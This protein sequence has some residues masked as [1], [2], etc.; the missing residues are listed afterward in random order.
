NNQTATVTFQYGLTVAYGSTVN[1]TPPTV[2]GVT[3][4]GVLAA[5]TGLSLSTTY[6]FR[7]VAVNGTGT[8]NGNDMI[9]TTGC[10]TPAA[11]G[12]ITGPASVCQSTTG[13]AYSVGAITDA[14]SYV[15]TVPAGATIATGG[16]TNSITVDFNGAAS[17]GNI[18]VY[19][20]SGC[21]SGASSSKAITLNARP[22]PVIT[23]PTAACVNSAGNVYSTAS[24][25][26]G[27]TWTV[28]AG[29]AIT[30]GTGTNAV[31][32][33]W[34]TAGPQTV[35]VNYTNANSCNATV[36]TV[37]NVTVN[38]LPVPVITGSASR[39]VGSIGNVYSTAAG[40][41]G[42]TWTVSAGGAITAGT[43][44]N[45]ITVTWNTAG[46]QTVSVNYT[47]AN[48][49]SAATATVYNVIVN[50]LPVPVITGS[51][52]VCVNSTGNIYTTQSG[53]T[54]YTWTIS[55]GGT[56]TAG[57]GTN[58]ITV[59]WNTA[60]AQS[61]SVN[62][63]NA[64]LC[65]AVAAT[66]YS[67]TVNP[68]PV[69]VITGSTTACVG[70][71]TNIYSTASGM[72]GYAWTVSAGGV[73]TAGA[74]TSAITVTW[75]TA[76]AKTVTVNYANS[77]GCMAATPVTFSVT[78][79]AGTT[80]TI[81]GPTQLCAGSTGV[82]YVTQ[83]GYSNY[84]WT[85]SYGGVIT[86]GLN[87]NLVTVDWGTAGQRYIAV[88]YQNT[89][90]CSAIAP[91]TYNVT[92]LSVPDPMITGN[93]SVCQG[94]TG[95]T[96]STQPL[97]SAYAWTVSAG[98][99]I[100]AG[101]G[102]SEI[103]VSWIAG[104]NQTVSVNFT[105]SLG[106]TALQPTVF[107]V[108]VA[109]LPATAG[110]ITGTSPV[111]AGTQGVVYSVPAITNA[112]SYNW[113]VPAGATIASGSG[114]NAITVNFAL[115]AASG[116]MKV[117]GV[118]TCGSGTSSPNYT[119]VVNPI[120]ATP[121]ITQH[122]DTLTSSA[123]TGNQW[124]LNGVIIPGATGKKHIAVYT[125]TYTV[126]VTLTGCSSAPSN[127][128]LVLPVSIQDFELS[129]DFDVYPNP[130]QG[131]FNIK[132]M[133]AKPVELNIEIYNSIGTLLWKQEKVTI[134]GTYI[135]PVDLKAASNGVYMVALRSRDNTIT[136]KVIVMK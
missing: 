49:C 6:H 101:A 21:A 63:A 45:A 110:T 1:A 74:G 130:N 40:M 44:T 79:A 59:T 50:P 76:G 106:C 107:N 95:V 68:L 125:G 97:N 24:G 75:N 90:G 80:P 104:G 69:P 27:Y 136:R 131:Q 48:S 38:P 127:G 123:N 7:A 41:T 39:C 109:P 129:H 53:M 30:A 12:A 15:W 66:V 119:L 8:T 70:I 118:N 29:G 58:A 25:M 116:I 46:A 71:T 103:T 55:A 61:V 83:P 86:S 67:V 77:F 3:A 13:V 96:Y 31:T 93:N 113:V 85:I 73:I 10:V 16:T 19:G 4:T 121:V 114:T 65:T 98:G 23:G 92:I 88:N 33:T 91:T 100:T 115:S 52:S 132:V 81:T 78:V 102:T 87:S 14:S 99:T 35:S 26:T 43:G 94:T 47:N 135:T 126:I 72:T 111:C 56:I 11:A 22:L 42:Y 122:L 105:N 28:S 9:F 89:S 124:Y 60:G 117:N 32:V 57:A 36:P 20:S 37:Y 112:T 108:T 5:I 18:T 82:T 62:Y 134:D 54:A 128:I 120:P 2:T 133:S 17:S 51:N 84:V 64:N 34:N